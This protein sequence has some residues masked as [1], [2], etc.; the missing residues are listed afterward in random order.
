[1]VSAEIHQCH[2]VESCRHLIRDFIALWQRR[3]CQIRRCGIFCYLSGEG[4]DDNPDL[5]P[6]VLALGKNT[7]LES[8]SL[9]LFGSMGEALCTAMK[10]RLGMNVTLE[11]LNLFDDRL[12][13]ENLLIEPGE[14]PI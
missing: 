5:S 12:C 6:V 4:I 14:R 1:M 10:D 8:L 11:S 2:T 13:D 3:F 7:G 9:H